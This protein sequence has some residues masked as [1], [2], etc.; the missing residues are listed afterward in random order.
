MALIALVSRESLAFDLFHSDNTT[1]TE[2]LADQGMTCDQ[3]HKKCFAEGNIQVN[4]GKSILTCKKLVV[5][6]AKG[7]QGKQELKMLEAFGDVHIYSPEDGYDAQSDYGCY[8]AAQQLVTLKGNPIIK[9]KDLEIYG[10]GPIV[11][12]QAKETAETASRATMKKQDRLL[13]ANNLIA[14]FKGDKDTNAKT[15]DHLIA[16]GNVIVSSPA[17]IA[18]SKSGSY[19]AATN[20][21]ELWDNVVITRSDGQIRGQRAKVDM[22][23][24]Q[25]QMLQPA[26]T[27]INQ[28]RVQALLLPKEKAKVQSASEHSDDQ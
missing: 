16:N 20:T 9:H 7:A 4:R 6:F 21:A 8:E 22:N 12:D 2:V 17:E 23:S 18:Q 25:S 26:N 19:Y 5:H 28:Q 1:V 3:D 14:Y 11:Y 27:P 13:Q 15:F 10:T 24:G